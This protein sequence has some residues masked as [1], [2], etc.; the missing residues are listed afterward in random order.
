MLRDR[1]EQIY[2]HTPK[3]IA[4]QPYINILEQTAD[5][6]AKIFGGVLVYY[7][8]SEFDDKKSELSLKDKML[9]SDAWEDDIIITTFVQLFESIITSK[10]S[11]L[12]K[13][14]SLCGSIVILDEVQALPQKYY[15]L[16][17]AVIKRLSDCYNV[18]F[19]LMTATQP[20]IITAAEKVVGPFTA[21]PLL[22]NPEIYFE[23]LHRTKIISKIDELTDSD[24]LVQFICEV[25]E[26]NPNY[27]SVLVVTNTIA[28]SIELYE[29][30]SEYG[31][32]LYLS[33]NIIRPD[34]KAVIEKAKKL[35]DAELPFTLVST[36]AIEAGVDLDF[37]VGFR[38]LAPLESI[39][40]VAGRVNRSGE[41]GDYRP[42]YLFNTGTNGYVYKFFN[43]EL[44]KSQL[45]REIPEEQ[46]KSL[47]DAYYKALL[48]DGESDQ[49]IYQAM[50]ELDYGKK[51]EKEK[52]NKIDDF[53]L[54]EKEGRY[55]NVLIEK[56][57]SVTKLIQDYCRMIHGNDF[58]F[59]VKAELKK[60][61]RRINQYVIAVSENRLKENPPVT[62][63]DLY[64]I[65]LDFFVVPKNQ[66][67][68]YYDTNTGYIFKSSGMK[69]Y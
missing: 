26:N 30:L 11:R 18:R 6:Y 53:T 41:K 8:G 13:L 50:L 48:T 55:R 43:L 33:T 56:D 39:I 37:D 65:D 4:A 68:E 61:M 15:S 59:E 67:D 21:A 35:I 42:L 34:R 66:L 64:G 63:R 58:S 22:K 49:D 20:E 69:A 12:L 57:D 51:S 38:D 44:T 52:R 62:F 25:R 60:L 19:I 1:L 29:K 5:E 14:D 27:R 28:Q 45:G 2:G 32:T 46:Y 3:I 24:S 10:N 23:D 47:C 9:I 31:Q 36:Q 40:Q 7:S 17:G 16:L 54:I